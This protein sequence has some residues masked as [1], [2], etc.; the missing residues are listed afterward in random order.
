[1]A[2]LTQRALRVISILEAYRAGSRD[3]LDAILPFFEP[4]LVEFKGD[5]LDPEKFAD[6]VREA[7]RWNFTADIV[8]ELIPRFENRKWVQRIPESGTAA[9]Y[10]VIYDNPVATT[11]GPNEVEIG[12]VLSAAV[13]EFQKFIDG[14]SPLSGFSRSKEE[15]S[16]ILVEWLVSIDAYSEDVLRQQAT[17]TSHRTGQLGISVELPDTSTLGSEE[18]YLCARFVKHLCDGG[19][20]FAKDLC[21]IA[22]VGLLTEVIQDFRQPVTKVDKTKVAVYLDGPVALDLLGVSGRAAADNIRLLVS[23]LQKIGASLR[24]FRVSVEELKRALDAVLKRSPP[25]RTGATADAIRRNEAS[26]AFVRQVAADPDAALNHYGVSIADRRLDQY[27]NDHEHFTEEL[28]RDL[29][30][31]VKWHVDPRPREHDATTIALVQRMR[32]GNQSSD[33][34][35]SRHI[36][37]TRNGPFAQLARRFCVRADLISE[38]AVSPVVHQ[39]QLATAVWLRTGLADDDE[40][41]PRHYLLAACERV[42]EL[43]RNVVDQ[44]RLAARNLTPEKAEQLELLLTQDRSVQLLMDKTLGV[45][46]VVSPANID[47]LV[48]SM[49]KELV[50]EIEE[51]KAAEIAA[52]NREAN[53]KIRKAHS[54]CRAAESEKADLKKILSAKEEEDRIAVG[55]IIDNVNCLMKR[56]KRNIHWSIGLMVLLIFL[57]PIFTQD[58]ADWVRIVLLLG[59]GITAATLAWF[60]ILD[61][62]MGIAKRLECWG[63]RKLAEI[64]TE[65]GLKA[66]LS[67][68]EV[69]FI[70]GDLSILSSRE[71]PLG[72]A[73][74]NDQQDDDA[75][76]HT[77]SEA[78][79]ASE[80]RS[81][82]TKR[83]DS[84]RHIGRISQGAEMRE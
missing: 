61:R 49:K 53:A 43:N 50:A 16:E 14:V 48:D 38:N 27:P 83:R 78:D 28:W 36:L 5:V 56:N 74:F 25:E 66:K 64:A 6:H 1:M 81:G 46:S 21:K 26:E 73:L 40:E 55:R 77:Y 71:P 15:L 10:R 62:P 30:A 84:K 9:A 20:P 42:L 19:S 52:I 65:R 3:I 60:Q 23:R 34:F 80:K 57:L 31:Q 32:Q 82:G 54:R 18:R 29:F 44:V 59:S 67:R 70:E 11:P 58:M 33:I 75:L 39:R 37:V 69:G 79:A 12:Q 8:E 63:H 35:Q 13:D 24:T 51:N 45:S 47:E 68:L 41:V 76:S 17:R 22:S 4:I 7:Y 72:L 2:L